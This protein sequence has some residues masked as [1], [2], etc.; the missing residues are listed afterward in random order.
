MN[1]PALLFAAVGGAILVALF[2]AL[3]PAPPAAPVAA[4]GDG[5]PAPSTPVAGSTALDTVPT[6]HEI[7]WIV[8]DGHRL[9]GPERVTIHA[10]DIVEI[11]IDSDRDDELHVHGYDL[12]LQVL[13]NQPASLKFTA[14]RAGR[15]DCEL[16]HAD[17]ALGALEVEPR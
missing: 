11:S 6:T 15:F 17:L 14:D 8:R 1:K 7:N 16:H 13:A 12:H 3:R 2:V 10:G 9:A 4:G 5:S